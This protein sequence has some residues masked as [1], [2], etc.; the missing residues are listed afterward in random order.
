MVT[1]APTMMMAVNRR[2]SKV[3]HWTP[4]LRTGSSY[5]NGSSTVVGG[6]SVNMFVLSCVRV[7]VSV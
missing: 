3:L 5:N 6:S 7:F 1:L 2:A 4:A